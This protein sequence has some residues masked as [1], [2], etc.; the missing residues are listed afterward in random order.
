MSRFV[1]FNPPR[2]PT[3]IQMLEAVRSYKRIAQIIL[4]FLFVRFAFFGMDSY[5]EDAPGGNEVATV[6]GSS[7]GVTEFEEALRDQQDRLRAAAGGQIDRAV[8]ES[9]QLRRSV[10]DNL[11]NRRVLAIYAAENRFTVTP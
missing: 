5:F 2:L 8:L 7:I 10:L 4:A 3:E 1:V 11:I 9:E 6:A